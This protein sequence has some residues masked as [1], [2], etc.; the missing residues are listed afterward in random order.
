MGAKPRI[1][2]LT[3]YFPPE[4]GAPQARLSELGERLLDRGWDV[5]ALTALPNYPTGHVF[6]GYAPLKPIVETIGRIR[7]AR[8]PLMPSQGGFTKRI[9]SYFSFIGSAMALGPRM[10]AKPDLLFVESPPL[11][12]GYAARYLA[13]RWSCPFVF[14]VS[15]LWPDSAVDMGIVKPGLALTMAQRL[16]VSLYRAAA[17]ATGQSQDIVDV[18]KQRAGKTPVELIT[19]GVDPKR[20]G[21]Q[22]ADAE[23]R[24]LVGEEPG[25]IFIFAGL[26]GLAQGLDQILDVAAALPADLPGRFVIVGDGPVRRHLE[27][28]I[29]AEKITRVRLLPMQPRNRVPALLAACDIA[30]ITIGGRVHGMVPNKIYEAMASSLPILLVAYGEAVH[31]VESAGAGICCEPQDKQAL[32]E[33]CRRLITDHEL[34][35]RASEGGRRAA[36]TL[37]HRD[38]IADRLDRFLRS[39]LP[40]GVG[41]C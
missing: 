27:D 35:K 7:T 30:L 3:Q 19:N 16:E 31:R 15:D 37:Y 22:F 36:E 4:M 40:G 9:A 17:G 10:C 1:C 24:A 34:R 25:P 41:T 11:F 26:L 6:P 2:I 14:N 33:A 39:V 20:F 8:V 12:I 28:R 23:A 21:A 38:Q 29:A 32:L 5:E 18:I 13:H